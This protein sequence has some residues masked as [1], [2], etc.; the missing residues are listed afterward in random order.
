MSI[1][2]L[3][4]SDYRPYSSVR[5][6]A[7]I[8]IGLRRMG[9]DVE[10][11]TYGE[12]EYCRIFR[13]EGISV[14]DF[15]PRGKFRCSESN[16][17]RNRLVEGR[18]DI[19]HLFNSRA[20]ITGLRAARGLPVKVVLYRGYTGNIHWYDPSAYL[21]FLH[22][23]ADK[24]MCL[25]KSVE[26]WIAA[27]MPARNRGKLMTINKGHSLK[28][29]DGVQRGDLTEIGVPPGVINI[30]CVA[31][32]RPMKGMK[33]LMRAI[34]LLPSDFPGHFILIGKNMDSPNLLRIIK[35]SP[36][37][38]KVHFPGFRKDVLE[39]VKACDVFTLASVMGEATTKAV[40]E[41]MALGVPPV[42][43]DVP[44]NRELVI[45]HSS[46]LVVPMRDPKALAAALIQICHDAALR[47]KLAEGARKQIAD[48][49]NV[50]R[51]VSEVAGMYRELCAKD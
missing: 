13:E 44:G 12:A 30:A 2:V 11:M 48:N 37:R 7:E 27:Q 29:Y 21:K 41:A 20:I 14:I 35:G 15:H 26:E 24:I 33:Y 31:N 25:A 46:G 3:V 16:Y 38:E 40:M 1:K 6:E 51:T 17:I 4:I 49:F 34:T 23:R 8:F 45:D 50:E 22:P 5:P 47:R 32:A 18:H 28:W 10:I 19:L 39:L 36:N 43:S 9:F 42:I